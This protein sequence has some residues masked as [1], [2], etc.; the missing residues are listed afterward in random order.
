MNENFI[1]VK[2]D[3]F[4]RPD[5]D[6][7][8]M[9][10][11]GDTARKNGWPLNLWLTPGRAPF[12]GVIFLPSVEQGQG[13]FQAVAQQSARFWQKESAYLRT[14]AQDD[15]NRFA[16]R[17][18][19]QSEGDTAITSDLFDRAFSQIAAQFDP[20]HG[21]FGRVPKFPAPS[22]IDFLARVAARKG[23]ESSQGRDAIAM[24]TATL[25]GMSRGGLRDHLGG[26]FFRYA[27]DEAWQRPYFEKM[28]LDQACL[29]RSYLTGCVVTGNAEFAA[30]ARETLAYA[31][32][33][34]S[35]P[36]G[37]FFNAEHSES[38]PEAGA[39]EPA[40]GSYYVWHRDALLRGAGDAAS[41]FESLYEPQERGNAPPGSDP[42][43][44]FD[45][46]N[47][48][49]Q[50]RSPDDAAHR[51]N[52][53]RARVDESFAMGSARLLAER[54]TRPRPA[55]DRLVITQ[56]N[57]AMISAFARASAVLREPSYLARAR[58]CSRYTKEH[59]WDPKSEQ[60]FR[61][62]AD[63]PAKIP[64]FAEDYAYLIEGLLDLYEASGD[65]EWLTW[66]HDLRRL[67]DAGFFDRQQGGYFDA[68]R[69]TKDL[70]V[71][72]KND[73][74]A[75]SMC[76]NAVAGL[77]LARL[78]ALFSQP[79][80]VAAGRQIFQ[81]FGGHLSSN[82]GV[83]SGL[84]C[85]ADALADPLPQIIIAGPLDSPDVKVA[86]E[87]VFAAPVTRRVIL[88]A[89]GAEGAKWITTQVAAFDGFKPLPDGRPAV[90]FCK[91]FAIDKGPFP[92]AETEQQLKK[93]AW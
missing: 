5:L 93:L 9:R 20:S 53:P 11:M 50:V 13:T 31:D 34:L 22:R 64:A 80:W 73:D 25:R 12:R 48:L 10:Y 91:N 43:N 44:R 69:Q 79:G 15:V 21:G 81:S 39:I 14:Q 86:R 77:N 42:F 55:L 78:A 65:V 1:N 16:E 85:A 52:V 76:S 66:S 23:R 18:T 3:R 82:P 8:Y 92:A 17:L 87:A 84:L 67:F 72:M 54:A 2:V 71:R 75:S 46:W 90:Y 33:E 57:G 59:L 24:L 7:F 61:C 27:L 47:L 88:Y 40:E 6:R 74:D 19:N 30:T 89:D 28:A 32:R 70:L 41:V 29:A 68:P 49:Y 63:R 4:E 36:E 37:G 83:V 51:L 62:C 35:H 56:M 45:G 26:G 60:L 38:L 58:R